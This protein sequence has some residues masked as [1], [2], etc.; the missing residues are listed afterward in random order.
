M[1]RSRHLVAYDI[2]DPKRL[3]QVHKIMKGFGM[4]F[5]YSVFLCDLTSADRFRLLQDLEDVIDQSKD[6]IA[7]VELGDGYDTSMFTFLGPIPSL[8]AKGPTIL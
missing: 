8:P 2:R 7:A 5:Q 1:K 4:P 6:C 3:R